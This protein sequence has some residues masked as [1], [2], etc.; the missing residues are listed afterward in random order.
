VICVNL[1]EKVISNTDGSVPH[2]GSS[3]TFPRIP[4]I[5]LLWSFRFG[6]RLWRHGRSP[7]CTGP[8]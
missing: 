3:F 7:F 4:S 5:A 1:G 6:C 2:H 8:R